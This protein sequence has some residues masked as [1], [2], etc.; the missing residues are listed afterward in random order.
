MEIE[1]AKLVKWLRGSGL[2][3]NEIKTELCLFYKL[4]FAPVT[5]NIRGSAI[6]S[7]NTMGV[8][9]V[10]FDS[11]LQWVQHIA[12]AIKKANIALSAIKLIRKY[13][14]KNE[15]LTLLTANFYSRLYYNSEIWLLS[16]LNVRNKK[17]LLSSSAKALKCTMYY[18]GPNI[19]FE[20]IHEMS[21]RATPEMFTL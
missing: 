13:F 17:Q 2:K 4:D 3:V 18:P 10:L 8:L 7:K 12:L 16:S 20:E 9:G 1:L 6:T 21:N 19:S 11:K 5:I 14:N 15:L